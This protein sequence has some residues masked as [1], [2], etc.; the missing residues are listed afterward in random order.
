MHFLTHFMSLIFFDNQ[1]VP[2]E[3]IG[4]KWANQFGPKLAKIVSNT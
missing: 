3:I 2:K 1:G 4:M